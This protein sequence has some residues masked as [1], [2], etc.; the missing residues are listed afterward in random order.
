MAGTISAISSRAE[1]K[2]QEPRGRL[3]GLDGIRGVAI[4]LVLCRHYAS[5]VFGGGGIVGVDLFFVLSGFLITSLL[6]SE[7][8]IHAIIDVRNFYMR[9]ALRL[10]PAL[11]TMAA[12]YLL[13]VALIGNKLGTPMSTALVGVGLASIYIFNFATSLH[14]AVPADL[15]P[16]WTLSVEEQ[17][18]LIWPFAIMWALKRQVSGRALAKWIAMAILALWVIRIPMWGA[19]HLSIYTVTPTWADALMSG[20]LIA[21]LR[22]YRLTDSLVRRLQPV[23][24]YACWA[25][26]LAA[27]FLPAIKERGITY[28][29]LLPI[30][31]V[32]MAGIMVSAV[33]RPT[34]INRMLDARLLLWLGGL[35]YSLYLWNYLVRE[36]VVSLTHHS[37]VKA[38]AIGMP[39]TF[40]LAICS[41]HIIEQPALRLKHRFAQG[42]RLGGSD[43]A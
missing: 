11:Y 37:S 27:A 33:D 6:L 13:V 36:S 40:A 15:G 41:R 35:S 26:V 20:A 32:A 7:W 9:R 16:L 1:L 17:F 28:I 24:V 39:L 10:L 23:L 31:C 14:I 25:V 5:P 4:G 34:V 12:V 18:Y 42:Y 29:A 8:D 38:F 30:F 22:H 2:P 3:A 43:R 21:T 19:W